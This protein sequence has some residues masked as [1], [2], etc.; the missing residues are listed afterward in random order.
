MPPASL[1]Q[2]WDSCSQKRLPACH[3]VQGPFGW[4]TALSIIAPGCRTAKM[5]GLLS[6]EDKSNQEG[7]VS[8]VNLYKWQ[9]A[10]LGLGTT[11]VE[12]RLSARALPSKDVTRYASGNAQTRRWGA[13]MAPS[14]ALPRH[15]PR[16]A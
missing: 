12:V 9:L 13:A 6:V 11:R 2:A 14:Q 5:G 10:S 4:I 3:R 8:Q 16:S 15:I 1:F 7:A